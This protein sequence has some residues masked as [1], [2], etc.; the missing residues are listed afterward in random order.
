MSVIVFIRAIIRLFSPFNIEAKFRGMERMTAIYRLAVTGLAICAMC[1]CGQAYA[2]GVVL[3]GG[4]LKTIEINPERA[5][6]LNKIFVAYDVK[7]VSAV[8]RASG[9]GPVKWYRY[10]SLGGGYAEE[11]S[12]IVCSGQEYTLPQV[13]P[14]MGYIVEEGTDRYYF[15][16]V[17]YIDHRL[18]LRSLEAAPVQE[19][20]I[21]HL[22]ATGEG[23]P[24]YYYS[25]NGRRFTLSQD[26]KLHYNTLEWDSEALDY[27]Q[28]EKELNIE[29]FSDNI[30]VSPAALSST[31]FKITGDRF[32]RE[33]N[34]L[35]E[36]ESDYVEAYSVEVRTYAEQAPE[37]TDPDYISNVVQGS[38]D[39]LGGSAPADITFYSV[40]TDAVI[41]HEWQMASDPDFENLINRFNDK[42]LHY[43]FRDEGTVYLRYIGSNAEGTCEAYGDT[44]TVHIGNSILKCPN[45]F[46]PGASPGVN[47]VWKVSYRSLI[48]FECWI[49]NRHGKQVFHFSDPSQG[50]DGRIGGR[51]AKPGVYYYVIEALGADGKR[52]KKSGDIN[53]INHRSAQGS[54]S[55]GTEDTDP[56]E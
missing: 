3:N 40:G 1:V 46:S 32:L 16:V 37:S 6:G 35:Q 24:I 39:G 22:L 26:I 10:S 38:D 36:A 48:E 41:H 54:G 11:V 30:Y 17:N 7:G 33:W 49:F 20:G 15:W 31:R 25:I 21:T 4:S 44:Y 43:V 8:Y 27:K 42:D 34:W 19:C 53:I 14:D 2:A 45:A 18:W 56:A 52:Y 5:T 9:N 12:G 28:I 29:S 23:D 55:G 51:L 47:D 50:W 13:E